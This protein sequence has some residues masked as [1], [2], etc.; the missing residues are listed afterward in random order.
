MAPN[1]KTIP[2]YTRPASYAVD[3]PWDQLERTLARY[4]KEHGLQLEPD[5][6][7][8]HVWTEAQQIA[9]VEFILRGGSSGKDILFNQPGWMSIRK[10]PGDFVLVDG[11][12]RITA[13]LRFLRNEIPA[14]GYKFSEYEG[15]LSWD[16][17]FKFHVNI[18][19]N[20]AAVLQW[21]LELNSGG[22]PH[23]AEEIARVKALFQAEQEKSELLK[24]SSP[25][26]G[27]S[28]P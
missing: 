26:K 25:R 20:R 9:Y 23:A 15:R 24:P 11:L 14:F 5:F 17:G 13:A 12:Q 1:F 2:K 18:L 3:L 6:Q 19:P 22:T 4:V 28:E 27:K 10:D 16:I 8:G 21:Y 7:R